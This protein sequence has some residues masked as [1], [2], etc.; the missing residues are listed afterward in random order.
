M[1][2][3][4]HKP[5]T[6]YSQ[7]IMSLRLT[8]FAWAVSRYEDYMR[9]CVRNKTNHKTCKNYNLF[10]RCIIWN[11]A[12]RK[13]YTSTKPPALTVSSAELQTTHLELFEVT[14]RNV[15]YNYS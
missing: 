15:P 5:S 12:R 4:T 1:V 7:V 14:R 9:S 13:D 11:S 8:P 3:L 2:A 10:T 6:Q